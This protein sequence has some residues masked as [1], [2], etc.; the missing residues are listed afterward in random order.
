MQ[1]LSSWN[2]ASDGALLTAATRRK[3]MGRRKAKRRAREGGSQMRGKTA[4]CFF[5]IIQ[6]ALLPVGTAGYLMAVPKLL[7]YSRK[8][9]V[10]A[11]LFASL[12][13]RYMQ[14]RLGTRP[15]EPAAR[16]MSV[17]PNVSRQGFRLETAPTLVGHSLTGYVPRIY[18]YPYPGEA[19]LRHQ[20]TARTSLYDAALQRHLPGIDQLVILGAGFDTRAFRLPPEERVRCF[21][22]DKP[23]TQAFKTRML[24]GAGLA[25]NR[26]SYVPA[27]FQTEDWFGKLL[28]A[29]YDPG[30]P[31]FFL[32]ESVTMYLD[33]GAVEGTLR[34]IAGTASGG[35]VAFDYFSAEIIASRSLLMRYARAATRFT[36]E[37]LTFG[38][39]NTPPARERAAEF[40]GAF[41]LALEE[42]RNFGTETR[43][44]AAPAGFAVAVVGRARSV[45]PAE[46][47][48]E[49]EA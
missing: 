9:A 10:S 41:G 15:D 30:R 1:G 26:A 18:R 19:P 36:G 44:R 38:I 32:W 34:R 47:Y 37:P 12:Y 4:A 43:R 49:G 5:R 48:E 42:H 23:R 33:R 20:Q 17:M 8:T 29:G 27:D 14:H 25:T 28:A 45:V 3:S 7:R 39:D 22:I 24:K 21:E 40:V 31:A 6:A 16:L 11:T 46:P 35:V 13:T 2:R